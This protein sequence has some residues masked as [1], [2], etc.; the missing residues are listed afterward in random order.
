MTEASGGFFNNLTFAVKGEKGIATG[1]GWV[2]GVT[3]VG[4]AVGG[5]FELDPES[6]QSMVETADWVASTMR[7][8]MM[9]ARSLISARPPAEDP[10]SLSFQKVAAASFTTGAGYVEESY[11]YHRELAEKLKKALDV[12]KGSDE[13]AGQDV[14][15][16]GG[17]V[18]R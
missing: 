14:N 18:I 1:D 11:N 17:G 2:K 15:D 8:Q 13:Q 7:D 6:A 12:Y 3:S 10:A 4:T 16:S 5:R 9:K